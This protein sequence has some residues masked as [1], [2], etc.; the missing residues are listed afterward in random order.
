ME[1]FGVSPKPSSK[2]LFNFLDSTYNKNTDL[3]IDHLLKRLVYIRSK[4]Q[5]LH[6]SEAIQVLEKETDGD[7]I[8]LKL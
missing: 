5:S 2:T 4:K 8:V 3:E 7:F 1:N 6:V